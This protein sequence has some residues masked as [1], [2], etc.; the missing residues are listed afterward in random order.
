MMILNYPDGE[1]TIAELERANAGTDRP[2]VRVHLAK[3]ISDGEVEVIKDG[4]KGSIG[5]H[6]FTYRKKTRGHLTHQPD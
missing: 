2:I 6:R 3:A 4:E 1:F 5:P